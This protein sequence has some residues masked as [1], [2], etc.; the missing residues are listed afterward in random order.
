[1]FGVILSTL[2]GR[3]CGESDELHSDLLSR[4]AAVHADLTGRSR[5]AASSGCDSDQSAAEGTVNGLRR[6]L[7]E[8]KRQVS[9]FTPRVS[10]GSRA[11]QALRD[12]ASGDGTAEELSALSSSLK[13]EYRAIPFRSTALPDGVVSFLTKLLGGNPRDKSVICATGTPSD[14]QACHQPRNATELQSNS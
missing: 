8:L 4:L 6:E 9:E 14:G 1:L 7:A 2:L 11:G 12:K 5:T 10:G 3:K 13:T